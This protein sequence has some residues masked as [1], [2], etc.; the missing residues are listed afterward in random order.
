MS[1]RTQ[2][3]QIEHQ[4][5]AISSLASTTAPNTRDAAHTWTSESSARAGATSSAVCRRAGVR[6]L[7]RAASAATLV[8]HIG[9]S[10]ARRPAQSEVTVF[11]DTQI[12]LSQQWGQRARILI[13]KLARSV[14]RPFS[15]E[16]PVFGHMNI[17][18]VMLEI[19]EDEHPSK[20][21]AG[22]R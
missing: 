5:S 11:S 15:I 7:A 8:H 1:K 6:P 18:A 10:L 17:R 4:L 14:S 22:F 2:R 3:R 16:R 9:T 12:M 21:C 13:D 19:L 20:S